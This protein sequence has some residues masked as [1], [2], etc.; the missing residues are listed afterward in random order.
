MANIFIIDDQAW[1]T[2]LCREGLAGE[3]HQVSATDDIE[4]VGKNVLSFKPDIVL[5]N[6]YLKHGFLVYDVL[7]DIRM[8]DPN[9]PV[10]IVTAYDTNLYCSR[11]AQA[12]GYLVKNKNLAAADELKQKVSALLNRKF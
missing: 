12:D 6:L 3:G 5:L 10:L 1:V 8:Q 9:L 7:R 11:L 2:D 4:S